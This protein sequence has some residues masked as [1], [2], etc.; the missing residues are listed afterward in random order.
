MKY[1]DLDYAI[2]SFLMLLGKTNDTQDIN[3]EGEVG[4]YQ[5]TDN[6]M[7]KTYL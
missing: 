5:A 3:L 6:K 7:G 4:P 2:K 1:N